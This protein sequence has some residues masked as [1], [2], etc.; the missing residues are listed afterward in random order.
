M[1]ATDRVAKAK[2]DGHTLI[3]AGSAAITKR[4]T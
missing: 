2:P 3:L 4:L 1:I